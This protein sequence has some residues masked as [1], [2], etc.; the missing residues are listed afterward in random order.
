MSQDRLLSSK[1]AA[2]IFGVN[3]RTITRWVHAGYFPEAYKSGPARNSRYRIP[4]SDVDA[5]L[6]KLKERQ[7]A[8]TVQESQPDV[9]L[10]KEQDRPG[11]QP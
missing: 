2:A 3:S 4:Q 9:S 7:E 1:E 6:Q 10:Q 8:T 5:F 11:N